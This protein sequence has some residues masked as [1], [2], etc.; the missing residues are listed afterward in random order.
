MLAVSQ[1]ALLGA[2]RRRS[3]ATCFGRYTV[4]LLSETYGLKDQFVGVTT[5]ETTTM[6]ATPATRVEFMTLRSPS[7]MGRVARY[8]FS[9]RR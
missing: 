3:L 1:F 6:T 7:C 4:G 2:A 5:A 8:A 9:S